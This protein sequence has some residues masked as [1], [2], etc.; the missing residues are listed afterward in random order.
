MKRRAGDLAALTAA[1][2]AVTALA[3]CSTK[4]AGG[5]SA[6][7]PT[8]GG[9]L[10]VISN[11]GPGSLDPVPTYNYA[12]Y[13]LERGYARQLLTYPTTS[14][15]GTSGPAWSKATALVPDAATQVPSIANG[16]VADGGLV[17]T[18]RIRPGVEWNS[19]PQRQVTAADFIREFQAFCNPG[20]FPVGNSTYLTSTIAGFSSYCAAEASH[21]TGKGAAAVTPAAIAAW[22]DSHQIAG[23]SAPSV[24]TL[25]VR[26]TQPASDFNDIMAL[27]F[28]SAR[29]KEYDAYLPGSA[30]LNQHMMSD[31]PYQISQYVPN[32]T[33]ILT[34]NPAWR[35]SADPVRHQYVSKVEVTMGTS[36]EQTVLT[37]LQA[38]SQDLFLADLGIPSQSIAGLQASHDSRLRIWPSSNLNP[39][40]ILNLRSPNSGGA[41]T[42]LAVRQAIEFGVNKSAIVKVAG[43]PALNKILSGAIPPGN[44]G[45]QPY[46]SYA[47]PGNE[48]NTA[49]CKSLLAS[50]G[51]PHGLT[52]SYLYP[53]DS[54]DTTVFQSIQGSLAA[55]GITLRGTPRPSGGAYFTDLGNT[56]QTNKPG[57]W[58]MATGSWFPDWFGNNGRTT[59]Q[60]L[61]Q[62]N[63]SLGT[64]NAGCYGSPAVDHLISEGLK[65]S[66][67]AAAAPLWHQAD[68]DVMNDAAIVPLT[69]SQIVGYASSRV[70][71]ATAGTANFSTLIQGW[72]Y[73]GIWLSPNTP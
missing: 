65:T 22:Q 11:T 9:T 50:A 48:G 53:N 64:V 63:C 38:D 61:F 29:P 34:R 12:G 14:P 58:D 67:P 17:Y 3:A 59:I 62:A 5:S 19:T 37:D 6:G 44:T 24:L 33:I 54:G 31:G 55:C 49:K 57:T 42:K 47:T 56:P 10:R 15:A 28:V 16:G 23:L 43:G 4:A 60:P 51:Y 69:S 18:Y 68:V 46:T 26:L 40:I 30:A 66:S 7:K 21:F 45:Y 52:L 20:Q 8:D 73:T 36:S 13:E 25:Q 27:P 35:Q 41:M 39:Y 71:S 72:D 32:K 1:I 2:A 70:H